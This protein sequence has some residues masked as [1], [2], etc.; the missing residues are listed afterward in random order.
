[1]I[2]ITRLHSISFLLWCRSNLLRY[3]HAILSIQ[4][5][6]HIEINWQSFGP[7]KRLISLNDINRNS[8]MLTRGNPAPSSSL[9]SRIIQRSSIHDGMIWRDILSTCECSTV[10]WQ[11]LLPT[12]QALSRILTFW[13]GKNMTFWQSMMN[14]TLEGIFQAKQHRVVMG[15]PIP[16]GFDDGARA[17]WNEQLTLLQLTSWKLIKFKVICHFLFIANFE[18]FW[19]PNLS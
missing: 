2:Q 13:N 8:L 7:M 6:I 16:I 9:I 19:T 10:D 3:H 18:D 1:M 14:L 11:M 12:Q 17:Q 4:L 15:I 5:S